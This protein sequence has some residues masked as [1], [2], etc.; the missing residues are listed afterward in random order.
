MSLRFST[1][2]IYGIR[3]V[4][5]LVSQYGNGPV[6]IRT[7]AEEE[8]IP[9]RYL[10]QLMG[11]LRQKGI[12]ISV[13][14]PGGGYRL[15]RSPDSIKLGEVL[16]ILEGSISLAR[17]LGN[18]A[19][20]FCKLEQTC[21]SRIFCQKLNHMITQFLDNVTLKELTDENWQDKSIE[22]KF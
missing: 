3:A 4:S 6:S 15:I 22:L 19:K 2:G 17:C 21:V 18:E 7:I 9:I 5:R 10:E 13:R 1:K 16:E 8:Q 11:R 20:S 14:G 12:L